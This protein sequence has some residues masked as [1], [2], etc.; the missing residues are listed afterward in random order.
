MAFPR[1]CYKISLSMQQG[2]MIHVSCISA[3]KQPQTTNSRM[4]TFPG[5]VEQLME[6]SHTV[7]CTQAG[8]ARGLSWAGSGHRWLGSGL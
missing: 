5:V 3:L 4:D 8:A 2:Y 1:E 7:L 6:Q